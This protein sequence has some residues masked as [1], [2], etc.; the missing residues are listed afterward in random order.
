MFVNL[1]PSDDEFLKA[2]CRNLVPCAY[3]MQELPE[4]LEPGKI[5]VAKVAGC[6]RHL[7]ALFLLQRERTQSLFKPGDGSK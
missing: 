5:R 6:G 4:S 1:R 7:L 3:L 2:F